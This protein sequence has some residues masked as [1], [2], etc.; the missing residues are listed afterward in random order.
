MSK[1]DFQFLELPR[2]MPKELPVAVRV[3]GWSEIYGSFEPAGATAQAERCLDCGNPYC[4]WKCP[5]HNYIPNWLKL[6]QENRLFE[7]ATLAHET[8]PLP[9]VCG[10]VCPQDRLCEG[11]CTLNTGFESVTIGA[12][13]KYI[14]DEAF[15]QGWRPDLSN[16]VATGKRVAVIGAGPAGL[17]CADRLARAGIQADVFDRYEEIGGLLTFGIPPFKLEK[18]VMLTRRQVLEAMGVQFHLRTEIGKDISFEQLLA[19]YDAVFVGTG[20][21]TAV[22][23]NLPGQN[24][25]G[26][27]EA[28]PFLIANARQILDSDLKPA[29]PMDFSEKR[30]VVLGGG[31]TAMDC[32]R[33]AI[34]LNAASVSCVYRRDEANMPGSR[35]EVGNARDEGVKFMFNHAPI[36]IVG[37]DRV[38]AVRLKDTISGVEKTLIADIV[39]TAFGFRASPADWLSTHGVALEES[40]RIAVTKAAP[41]QTSNPKIFAG[42]DNVR[43]ADLV[44][45]AVHDGREAG[46]AI[47]RWLKAAKAMPVALA[48]A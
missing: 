45:T 11:A 27:L 12:I 25:P 41:F 26:R 34:R 28:L 6:V 40:G 38:D 3:H 21:Y 35:R 33:T 23:A 47:A 20:A 13:E 8:N 43:G 7:A 39:I 14:V 5:V 31:D 42:G 36:A 2:K 4:E 1:H 22:D 30:I 16:V 9:E 15:K 46:L 19:D 10:R 32:V 37:T 24:L 29:T 44:V 48:T 18:Q 17:S